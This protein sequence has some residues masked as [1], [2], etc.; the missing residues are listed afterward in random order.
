MDE[1][2][3]GESLT[4]S[5]KPLGTNPRVGFA[6]IDSTKPMSMYKKLYMYMHTSVA[7]QAG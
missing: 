4:Y 2:K 6:W 1:R 5:N 3:N 7:L